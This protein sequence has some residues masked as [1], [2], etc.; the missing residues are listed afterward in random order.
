MTRSSGEDGAMPNSPVRRGDG[1]GDD[2]G[3]DDGG[4]DGGASYVRKT[5]TRPTGGAG[6]PAR[7]SARE[8]VAGRW[9]WLVSERERGGARGSGSAIGPKGGSASTRERGGGRGLGRIRPSRGGAFS[10]FFLFS[11]SH[12]HFCFFSF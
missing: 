9:G 3:G 11:K 12:F 5:T 6:L 4:G 2:G 1:R 7:G 10:F 8:R